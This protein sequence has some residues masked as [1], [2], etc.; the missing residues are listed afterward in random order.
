MS[1]SPVPPPPFD[2]F[3]FFNPALFPSPPPLPS[4]ADLF[5]PS[6]TTDLF[7]FLEHFNWEFEQEPQ[8]VPIPVPYQFDARSAS[9]SSHRSLTMFDAPNAQG[10]FVA[11]NQPDARGATSSQSPSASPPPMQTQS[12]LVPPPR[13]KPLLSTPQK[14]INHIMSE[15]KRRNAIRDGYLQLTSLLAPAGNGPNPAWLIPTFE[16]RVEDVSHPGARLFFEHIQP[17]DALKNAVVAVCSWLYTRET[18]PTNVH[19]VLLV[20]RPGMTVPAYTTGSLTAKEIHV[21]LNHIVNSSARIKHEFLGVLTH[22]MVHCY[23]Y[24]A[25]GTCP[26]GLIEGLADWVRLHAGFIPPHWKPGGGEKWDAGYDATAYFLDWIEARYG[27]GIVRE[28]NMRLRDQVYDVRV[29]Q[30]L[31]GHDVNELWKLYKAYPGPR[32]VI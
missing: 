21:S 19:S 7:G 12:E 26:G 3:Q 10:T 20:L 28:L 18:A 29:F 5:T 6:E 24:N 4:S 8:N 16:L 30:D 13:V 2:D 25:Q 14:R 15:Q 1:P 32:G 17:A 22:E 31:T 9:P 11:G 23:Q 27:D